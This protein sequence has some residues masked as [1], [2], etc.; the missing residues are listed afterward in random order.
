MM[1]VVPLGFEEG[2]VDLHEVGLVR[3]RRCVGL[4]KQTREIFLKKT[5][6]KKF[7]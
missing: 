7:F 2:L 1:D 5:K 3:R 4:A 6:I